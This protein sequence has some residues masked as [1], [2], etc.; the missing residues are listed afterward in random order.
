MVTVTVR[1]NDPRC[2]LRTIE[3]QAA[4]GMGLRLRGQEV[5]FSDNIM[6]FIL[7][8][9]ADKGKAFLYSVLTTS[10]CF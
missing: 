4:W 3:S 9:V 8:S 10:K 5:R 1:G 7:R 2:R 6:V